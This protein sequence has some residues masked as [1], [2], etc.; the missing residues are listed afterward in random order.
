M[1]KLD[2][3]D[4]PIARGLNIVTWATVHELPE[5]DVLL[6]FAKPSVVSAG[7]V[8][9][10]RRV[11][12][13]HTLDGTLKVSYVERSDA[14]APS[15]SVSELLR[16]LGIERGSAADGKGLEGK[17]VDLTEPSS[18]VNLHDI[19]PNLQVSANETLFDY[20]DILRF[21]VKR[22]PGDKWGV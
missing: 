13:Y 22:Y 16:R 4:Q 9:L 11:E 14:Y 1:K 5:L 12:I 17:I 21:V 8:C 15:V 18:A 7:L 2:L 6:A 19:C 10:H 20:N 3:N